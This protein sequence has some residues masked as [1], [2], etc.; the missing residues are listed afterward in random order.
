MDFLFLL[1]SVFFWHIGLLVTDIWLASTQWLLVAIFLLGMAI[2]VKLNK[3]EDE[4][5]FKERGRK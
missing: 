2:F 4:E 1:F 5:A 3:E